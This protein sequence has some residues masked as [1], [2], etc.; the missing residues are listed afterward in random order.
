MR[1]IVSVVI[2]AFISSLLIGQVSIY[3]IQ[4]TTQSGDGSYPSLYNGQTVTV[5]GIVVANNFSG[6]RFFISSSQ[7]GAWNGLFVYDNN[8]SPAIG[9]SV[10]IKGLI[11]EYNG[12]T[13]IKDLSSF[14][15]KSTNNA[16]P[17]TAKISTSDVKEEAYEG[18]LVEINDCDVS[19]AYDSWG[20]WF[21][22]DDSGDGEITTGIFDLMEYGFPVMLNYTFKRIVGVIGISYGSKKLNPRS[23]EDFQSDENNFVISTD[24][25]IVDN[26]TS[27][28]FPVKI[29]IL[30]Q[31]AQISTYSLQILYDDKVVE[32]DGYNKTGTISESGT[33]TDES[34][35]GNI[36]L[37]YSG[38]TACDGVN[39]LVK[40]ILTPL[41]FGNANIEFDEISINGID[42]PYAIAGDLEYQ[43]S[44]CSIPI[45]DTLTIVQRPL[46]NIPSIAIP[47]E[48]FIIECFAPSTTT[49]WAAELLYQD[50]VVPLNISQSHYETSLEKW[51]LAALIPNVE[52]YELYDL[53]ISASDGILDTVV[54]AVKVIDK[55]KVDYYFVHITDTHLPNHQ[56]YGDD[57]YETDASE[58]EDFYEVI[59]DI[60]LIQPEFVLLTGDLINE[61]ELEDFECLRNHTLSVELLQKLEVP[62]YLVPGNHDLGG[63]DDTPPSQGT[64]R[65]EWW[66]FFGWRQREIPPTKIE[67]L[68]HDY[69][70]DY[71]KTHFVGLEAYD[72][73]DSYMYDIYGNES[74]ISPQ[75]EWLNNDLTSANGMTKVLFYHYDFKYEL[76][77]ANLGVDMALWGH[78]HKNT[79]D[80]NAYPASLSTASTCDGN[81]TFRVIRVNDGNLQAENSVQTHLNGDMLS[82]HF[83][84]PNDGSLDLVSATI[85]NNYNLSFKNG[86]IKFVMPNSE[87]GYQVTDGTLKQVL[88]KDS[89]TICYVEVNI[90]AGGQIMA[91]IEKKTTG[92]TELV[93][94]SYLNNYPNPFTNEMY[95]E[96]EIQQKSNVTIS[97]Y[98]LEG[99][100]I[101]VLVNESKI[102]GQYSVKWDATNSNGIKVSEGVYVY[103]YDLNGK[104]VSSG[105]VLC[106]K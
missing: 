30:N 48:E 103:K 68:T 63:W 5:G 88:E 92:I 81:R 77:I 102:P 58:L 86:L 26:P 43:S 83:D 98:N 24:E 25:R 42:N 38:S 34:S 37:N 52:L 69:S 11:T 75:I 31:S 72:N 2:C 54:N 82:I 78:N 53:R 76:D 7:G 74:F 4:Y 87:F 41:E 49:N 10:L 27:F 105:Q 9:D 19:S 35:A 106:I 90:P 21:V 80:I 65:R 12:Y 1:K 29:S 73:Y 14:T 44:E 66:R 95:M 17:E 64:A 56:F 22:D 23:V 39:T 71:G 18:V 3:D 97:I 99:K 15:I 20:N 40:L 79:G 100:L 96:Y 32:Y 8:Y 33:I 84:M 51:T 57:G 85:I 67:Y 62:V 47:G 60:N 16:L 13:E 45:G 94:E 46:L 93:K 36:V 89:Y 59:K 6:N 61:G 91:T 70:F 50:I 55:Y 104:Q 28:D 101:R